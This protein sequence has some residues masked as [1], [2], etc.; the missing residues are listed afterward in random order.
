MIAHPSTISSPCFEVVDFLHLRYVLPFHEPVV[1]HVYRVSS[2]VMSVPS[3]TLTSS[4]SCARSLSLWM[5][6]LQAKPRDSLLEQQR[7]WGTS[8]PADIE[9]RR[10]EA[11][12]KA[13]RL[14][15]REQLLSEQADVTHPAQHY[16][17]MLLALVARTLYTKSGGL[18]ILTH[19]HSKCRL[20]LRE[21]KS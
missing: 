19:H 21:N 12:R 7:E 10:I 11:E 5:Y 3:P 14:D 13:A 9:R 16:A 17:S 20:K 6:V 4:H 18:V 1:S 2:K 8:L 15:E